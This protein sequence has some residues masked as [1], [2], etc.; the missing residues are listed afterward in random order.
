MFSF[1]LLVWEKNERLSYQNNP[2]PTAKNR[3]LLLLAKRAIEPDYFTGIIILYSPHSL[4]LDV[5][6]KCNQIHESFSILYH[7]VVD[8]KII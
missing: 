7:K 4:S 6:E 2:K 5:P 8:V 1:L 3:V